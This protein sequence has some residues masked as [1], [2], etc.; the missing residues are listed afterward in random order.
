MD[1]DALFTSIKEGF[2]KTAQT[3]VK[4]SNEI[5]EVT[6][7]RISIADGEA[8]LSKIMRRIGEIVY[9]AYKNEEAPE[10]SL[11]ELC[12]EADEKMEMLD[13]LREKLAAAKKMKR[14]QACK[15]DMDAEAEFCSKCGA[16]FEN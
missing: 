8:D 10:V 9:T 13:G 11:E 1:K 7:L 3:A 5:V 16:H 12:A 6:K 2:T 4:K 15:A 14:C